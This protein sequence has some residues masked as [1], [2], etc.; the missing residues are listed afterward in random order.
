MT[1]NDLVPKSETYT[2]NLN[3]HNNN[4]NMHAC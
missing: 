3:I 4:M 1:I 2:S